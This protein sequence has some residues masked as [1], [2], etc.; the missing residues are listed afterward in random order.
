MNVAASSILA[1]LCLALCTHIYESRVQ[2]ATGPPKA[3]NKR[4]E[5]TKDHV[6][7]II[8]LYVILS[9]RNC[10]NCSLVITFVVQEGI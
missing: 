4:K 3:C 10:E 9:I 2:C 5:S 6:L 1:P 7:T 8:Y